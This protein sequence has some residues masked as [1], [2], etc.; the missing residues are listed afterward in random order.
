MSKNKSIPLLILGCQRSGTTLLAA[1]LGGHSEINMLFESKTKD[2]LSLIGKKYSGN[3]LLTWRQIRMTQRSSRLGHVYNR[4]VNHDFGSK[5]KP[6]VFRPY[7]NGCMSI[8]DY[9][10]A[11]AKIICLYRNKDEV[12]KSMINRTRISPE[13]A[14]L[15][16]DR[17]V[18]EMKKV[19]SQSINLDFDDLVQHP[20]K[21]LTSICKKL[22]LDFEPR[23]LKG[24]EYNFVY[25][26]KSVNAER[27]KVS[28]NI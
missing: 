26:Q 18:N 27:A 23:M 17:A 1:M 7:P 4:L 2:V 9:I 6:H 15:E 25:P 22:D 14:S 11:G 28:S 13:Q 8:Q 10:D 16:Y 21:I 19:E 20:A 12:L 3:K 5:R 24:P